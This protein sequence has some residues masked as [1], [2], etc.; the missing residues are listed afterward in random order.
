MRLK[1][2]KDVAEELEIDEDLVKFID[3]HLFF[4]I[5]DYMV[6]P[7]KWK[8]LINNFATLEVRYNAIKKF[9]ET[10]EEKENIRETTKE[11]IKLYKE[12]ITIGNKH[13]Q[14]QKE[15]GIQRNKKQTQE[16]KNHE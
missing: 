15:N 6:L 8:F 12:L 10:H 5:S 14:I 1:L 4:C 2:Y 3:D 13:K 7:E 16:T 9:V 11:K